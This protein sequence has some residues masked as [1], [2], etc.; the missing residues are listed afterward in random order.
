MCKMNLCV[1]FFENCFQKSSK[2]FMCEC[3]LGEVGFGHVVSQE[4]DP[5]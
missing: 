4:S 5:V 1:C 3:Y 2:T